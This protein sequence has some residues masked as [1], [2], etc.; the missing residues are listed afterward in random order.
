M[1]RMENLS[2][3]D[4]IV[5]AMIIYPLTLKSLLFGD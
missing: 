2:W 4:V 5:T 3:A 1:I